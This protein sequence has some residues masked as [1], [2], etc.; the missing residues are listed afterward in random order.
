MPSEAF[1]TFAQLVTNAG[2]VNP[3]GLPDRMRRAF[4]LSM[5]VDG[6][7]YIATAAVKRPT[8]VHVAGVFAAAGVERDDS[9]LTAELGWVVVDGSYRGRRLARTVIEPLRVFA[10]SGLR[11]WATTSC[12]RM[13]RTLEH[14]GF[15]PQGTAYESSEEPG[16]YLRL[17]ISSSFAS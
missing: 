9:E 17:F 6:D 12:P 1:Q 3:V 13:E 10:P 5:L 11:T 2:K 8:P 7:A 16:T 14:F 15:A 4:R